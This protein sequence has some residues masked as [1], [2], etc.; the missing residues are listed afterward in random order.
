MSNFNDYQIQQYLR[1]LHLPALPRRNSASL[2]LLQQ[3][4]KLSI[5]YDNSDL[6]NQIPLSLQTD[7]LYQKLVNQGKGGIG[8][9]LNLL[10]YDLLTDAGFHVDCFCARLI[11]GDKLSLRLHPIL[12][13]STEEGAFLCDVG[14]PGECSR[15]ALRLLEDWPQEDG[16]GRYRFTKSAAQ[17][18]TLWQQFGNQDWLPLY[19]F[20]EDLY[21]RED[22]EAI[23]YYC[24]HAHDCALKQTRQIV[25]FSTEGIMTLRGDAL[26]PVGQHHKKILPIQTP[27]ALPCPPS[28]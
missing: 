20:A 5:P 2:S 12:K 10:F 27:F 16:I 15:T 19:C 17:G 13:I 14:Y 28:R 1:K 21:T 6:I 23:A 26:S 11:E 25:H 9:E 22:F 24:S 7:A 3:L 4:H 8:L 18:W